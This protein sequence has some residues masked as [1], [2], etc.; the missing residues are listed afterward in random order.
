MEQTQQE[1][2]AQV[3]ELQDETAQCRSRE[4]NYVKYIRE[5]EQRTDDLERA[6]R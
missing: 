1:L 6:Q 2:S 4:E 3:S 5:L